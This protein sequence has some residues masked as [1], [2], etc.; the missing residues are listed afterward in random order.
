MERH[1]ELEGSTKD[2][3]ELSR[4]QAD[5]LKRWLEEKLK[6]WE[7]QRS[8]AKVLGRADTTGPVEGSAGKMANRARR[9]Q[10]RGQRRDAAQQELATNI[11]ATAE[12]VAG[13]EYFGGEKVEAPAGG[14]ARDRESTPIEGAAAAEEAATP[15]SAVQEV[16][17]PEELEWQEWQEWLETDQSWSCAEQQQLG[18][19]EQ[20][21]GREEQQEGQ[22]QQQ[23]GQEEH[24]PLPEE[25]PPL[26]EEH[27]RSTGGVPTPAGGVPIKAEV[28]KQVKAE[29]VDKQA[30]AEVAEAELRDKQVRAEVPCLPVDKQVKTKLREGSEAH[31]RPGGSVV[32]EVAGMP[33]LGQEELHLG[34]PDVLDQ[35]GGW[36]GASND[37][38]YTETQAAYHASTGYAPGQFPG[39]NDSAWV[40][41]PAAIYVHGGS[42]GVTFTGCTFTR[43]GASA[44]MF[45]GGSSH[46]SV[47][48]STFTDL[49]GSAVMLGQVDDWG[50]RDTA[51][52]NARFLLAHN[53][54]SH[55]SLEYRGSPGITAAYIRDSIVEHNVISHLSYS[56]VSLGWGWGREDSYAANNSVRYNHIHH[57]MCGPLYD[58]VSH[59]PPSHRR[60]GALRFPRLATTHQSPQTRRHSPACMCLPPWQV[61]AS[62]HSGRK[63]LPW[64]RRGSMTIISTTS[65]ISSAV[66]TMT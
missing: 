9:R 17:A 57:H 7:E 43:M 24:P 37:L 1:G 63:A 18:R 65:A 45:S 4:Q 15:E 62:T 6:H 29:V 23:R 27:R 34:Q 53:T 13:E 5:V 59:W 47:I 14:L 51:R 56:G 8:E 52:Q 31:A 11:E 64:Y 30:K 60:R 32:Q 39:F 38:G 46:G 12:V 16:G 28:V 26:A 2:T 10:R 36:G 3:P 50:L 22:Q 54:I 35:G 40:A 44:V 20:R 58:G 66:S 21:L 49:S 61:G 41:V 48:N 19:E 42:A 55:T 25:H 33:E